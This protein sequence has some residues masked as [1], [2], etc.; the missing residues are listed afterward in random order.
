MNLPRIG[1]TTLVALAFGLAVTSFVTSGTLLSLFTQA[2]IYAI[3]AIG[4][5]VLLRQNGMVSFGHALFFG[6]SGYGLGIL[7]QLKLMPAEAAIL[8]T[9]VG[10]ALAAF[11]IGLVIVR[12]RAVNASGRAGAWA[13]L[14]AVID[15][16]S[17]PPSNV[18]G[19]AFVIV[20][21]G[22]RLS[23]TPCPDADYSATRLSYGATF[24]TSV[25]FWE[26]ASSDFTVR[27]PADGTYIVY[28]VHV[29]TSGNVSATPASLTIDY[30]ALGDRLYEGWAL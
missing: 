21:G 14:G 11:V 15:G 29:D 4:I 28:A 25:L 12:V 18:A 27:P 22:L 8:V 10:L 3:F 6:S 5:G 30:V 24:E 26:G 7:L 9:L 19:L 1:L 16:K 17:A 2:I 13:S 20:A 23:W